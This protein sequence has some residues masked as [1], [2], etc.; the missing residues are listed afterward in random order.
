MAELD[1]RLERLDGLD[2]P[3]SFFALG[4]K[5]NVSRE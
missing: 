4:L 5:R 1:C 3:G 2:A